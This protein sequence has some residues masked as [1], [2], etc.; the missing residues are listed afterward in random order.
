MKKQLVTLRSLGLMVVTSLAYAQTI[1]V[2][3]SW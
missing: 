3:L 1:W 2:V